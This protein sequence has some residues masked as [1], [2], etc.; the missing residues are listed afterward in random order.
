MSDKPRFTAAEQFRA[1]NPLS[2]G[3]VVIEGVT[4]TGRPCRLID[5]TASVERSELK[6]L[7]EDLIRNKRFGVSG[8]SSGGSNAVT[9]GA[10]VYSHI[11]L[12]GGLYRLVV[13]PYEARIERF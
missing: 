11:Q 6:A 8:I 4:R 3:A 10:P 12:G 5:N 2:P 13:F 9:L 7:L 1:A